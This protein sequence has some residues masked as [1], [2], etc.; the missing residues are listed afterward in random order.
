MS[1]K[2]YACSGL[3]IAVL[4]AAAPAFAAYIDLLKD[5][6]ISY[7]TEEDQEIFNKTLK[8]TLNDGADGETRTWSNSNTGASGEMTAL[9]TFDRNGLTCRTLSVINNA[10]GLSATRKFTFCKTEP[11]EWKIA[12]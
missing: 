5:S 7:F 1:R 9:G 6:P 12:D 10:D 4:A 3:L 11:G 8:D 2:F